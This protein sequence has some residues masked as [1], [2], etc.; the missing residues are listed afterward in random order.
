MPLFCNH[1]LPSLS[2]IIYKSLFLCYRNLEVKNSLL[3]KYN[4]FCLPLALQ[5]ISRCP[6]EHHGL[7]GR[8]SGRWLD[9]GGGVLQLNL[10]LGGRAQLQE[11]GHRGCYLAGYYLLS[12][13][14]P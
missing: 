11:V 4:T 9:H 13:F 3:V 14:V 8:A 2:S 7:R 1:L 10:M 12:W 6:P 5:F